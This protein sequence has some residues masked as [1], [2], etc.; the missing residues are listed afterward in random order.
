MRLDR[1]KTHE[2]RSFSN[3]L[4]GIRMSLS[5]KL[6][7]GVFAVSAFAVAGFAQ[8]AK[9]APKADEAK[10]VR[11]AD[12]HGGFGKGFGGG[13]F[14][15]QMGG[16]GRHG[17]LGIDLTDQQKAQIH[18]ILQANR[19]D[20]AVIQEAKTIL[21]AKFA[22]TATPE[23][24][25]RL[26]EL[27]AQGITTARRVHDQIQGVLTAEQKAQIEQRKQQM[28]QKMQ[29]LREK[30]REMRDTWQKGTPKAVTKDNTKV[31]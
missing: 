23:Q 2:S 27:K 14:G 3:L 17:I 15:R 25:A 4:R 30:R 26:Q 20:P 28:K 21:R 1:V 13:L 22:G 24:E 5:S 31:N 19:P 6:I 8:E 12:R 11:K 29:E 9:E 18:E 10:T 16:I 7:A